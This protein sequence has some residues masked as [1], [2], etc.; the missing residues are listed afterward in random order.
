MGAPQF[1]AAT[2]QLFKAILAVQQEC[3]I[4]GKDAT[5]PH[6]KSEYASLEGIWVTIKPI[7]GKHG[8]FVIQTVGEMKGELIQVFTTIVHAASGQF[9]IS[10]GEMPIGK[11]TP[12]AVGS[13][14][15][16]AR[17]YFLAPALGLVTGDED[18]D[19]EAAMGREAAQKKLGTLKT[20]KE[21]VVKWMSER[22]N[23]VGAWMSHV[24]GRPVDEKLTLRNEEEV[25][26]LEEAVNLL[27]KVE[28]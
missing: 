6:F 12:Q 27:K 18:D 9:I 20:R 4:I 25:V 15:T 8:L 26:K 11:P 28:G 1:S 24:L 23:N 17:R 10:L 7:L 16:Y 13:A 21:A 19:A 5:N 14:I 3:G 2:D 22:N